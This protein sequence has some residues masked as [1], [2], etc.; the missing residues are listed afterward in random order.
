MSLLTLLTVLVIG[1]L[2][3][4]LPGLF[5]VGGA[6]VTVPALNML[7]GIPLDMAIGSAACQVLGPATTGILHRQGAGD[8]EIKM[9]SVMIG[10]T[11]VGLWLGM[12]FV[13]WAGDP[14]D[15]WQ[16]FGR[17]VPRL[18]SIMMF[19][20]F[21]LLVSLTLVVALDWHY[22][23]LRP[24]ASST[25]KLANLK[26]PPLGDFPELGGRAFS[27]PV[28]TTLG[29]IVGFL[30]GGMGMGGA[31]VLI[32]SLVSLVGVPLHR[33]ITVSLVLSWMGAIGATWG[34]ALAGRIDLWLV[35]LLLV[36]GTIGAK[37]GSEIGGRLGG[38]RLKAYF[39][40]VILVVAVVVGA[41][42]LH[43][44]FG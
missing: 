29:T 33:A 6:F 25:G 3:G 27:I 5:G 40:L 42:L 31:I 22:R 21:A 23:R 1:T 9:P 34:H 44:L 24:P 19:C 39:A 20:Y 2:V 12:K 13:D 37:I 4:V 8:L 14:T 32:P 16:L 38:E 28:L 7:A 43:L 30:N 41:R 36:G 10:G 35:S 18:E 17:T 11:V 15:V 26:L